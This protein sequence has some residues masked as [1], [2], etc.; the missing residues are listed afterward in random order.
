MI[1][2]QIR[3]FSGYHSAYFSKLIPAFFTIAVLSISTPSLSNEPEYKSSGAA[4]G[5]PASN[6][7]HNVKP[8]ATPDFVDLKTASVAFNALAND[9]DTDGDSLVL[10]A[11]NAKFGA[12]AYTPQGLIAYAQQAGHAR[13]DQIIYSISDGRGGLAEGIVEMSVR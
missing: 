8:E 1:P 7:V 13:P 2:R 11:A 9:V 10:V 12:V 5:A 4:P 3:E 6:L